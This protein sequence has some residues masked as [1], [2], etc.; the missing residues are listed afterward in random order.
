MGSEFECEIVR[1]KQVVLNKNVRGFLKETDMSMTS[2]I[3]KLKV[4]QGSNAVLVKNLY[5]SCDP[6][7]RNMMTKVEKSNGL[8]TSYTPA[9]PIYGF[10][11]SKVLDSGHKEFVK[12]D[13]VWGGTVGWEEYSLITKPESLF[14]IHHTD[15]DLLKNKFGFD[16]A[17]NYKEENNLDATL[18]KYFPDGIDIYFEN[19]GGRILDEVLLKMR[20]HGRIA[21]S[22]MISQ[23][24]LEQP[25]GIRNLMHLVYKRV[26]LKGFASYDY[27]DR[28]PKYLNYILPLIKQGN[29]TYLEDIAQGLEKGPAALVG[30]FSGRNVGKQLVL[31][32]KE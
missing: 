31:I 21:L 28:Y 5:L 26:E 8:L 3:M 4:P 25:E 20:V 23:Y 17:F 18:N 2:R 29:I 27:F 12:G 22:G 15:V 14:K 32:T 1:N 6:Y 16:D 11:V 13:L 10:G 7:M 9:S 19:A 30:L 24:N